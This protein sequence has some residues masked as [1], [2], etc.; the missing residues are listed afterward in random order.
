M[1]DVWPSLS[2]H[3][4]AERG[5]ITISV[6]HRGS[7]HFGK[8][9]TALMHRQLGTWEMTDLSTAAAWLRAKP[10]VEGDRIG[11]TGS[12]YGG[13]TTAMVLTKAAGSFNF[14]IAGS[15]VTDWQLYDSVYTER[16]MDSPSENPDGYKS[17]AVL[18]WVDRYKGG[19]RITHGTTDDNV[20]MQQT[21]QLV[22]WLTTHDKRFELMIY[23]DS[24]HGI[25]ASQRAHQARES[26]DFWVRNLLGGKLPDVVVD[27]RMPERADP[28]RESKKTDPKKIDKEKERTP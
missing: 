1:Q 28:K 24:R 7:G 13:Y 23:P 14:G 6:D 21:V 25:Q 22:D 19:L 20:H 4:W 12:S 9:G 27:T 10:F 17:G 26:H 11:I 5:V 2:A 3:Y 18:T 15:S 8:A 16:Y